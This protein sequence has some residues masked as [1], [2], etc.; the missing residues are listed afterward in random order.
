MLPVM[1][2]V[3]GEETEWQV[4]SF[5]FFYAISSNCNIISST[6]VMWSFRCTVLEIAVSYWPFSEQ[7]QY[8]ADQNLF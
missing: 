4:M 8:L 6:L 1:S 2:L 3:Y 5:A 7:L